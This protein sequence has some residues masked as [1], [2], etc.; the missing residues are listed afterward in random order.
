MTS[1]ITSSHVSSVEHTTRAQIAMN[2]SKRKV[3]SLVGF[4]FSQMWKISN[5]KAVGLAVTS[6]LK[7][8]S[9]L[10]GKVVIAIMRQLSQ[11]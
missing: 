10:S 11:L 9:Q 4:G 3:I 2:F 6:V 1:D 8:L 5:A 7:R